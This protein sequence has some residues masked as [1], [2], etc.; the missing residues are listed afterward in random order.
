MMDTRPYN[1]T[2]GN[3]PCVKLQALYLCT[4]MHTPFSIA[5][6]LRT[7]SRRWGARTGEPY[8]AAHYTAQS[9]RRRDGQVAHACKS[10]EHGP[11]VREHAGP[12]GAD[13]AADM[14]SL[15]SE[16]TT[17]TRPHAT[18]NTWTRGYARTH[19]SPTDA[20]TSHA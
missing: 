2:A 12:E 10:V 18:P 7:S 16:R 14:K 5:Q 3:R 20:Q 8:I 9:L 1:S 13:A 11:S 19:N 6:V 15:L 4:H 17:T